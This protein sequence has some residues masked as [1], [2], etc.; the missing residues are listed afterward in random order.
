M[1]ARIKSIE[2]LVAS[3]A[4]RRLTPTLGPVQLTLLGIGAV[5]GSGI[6]VLTAEAAQRA[7]PGMMISFLIAGF[8]CA[9][10]ALCYAE[11]TAMIPVAGS[12]YTYTYAVFGELFAWLIGWAL[13]AEYTVAAG[14]VSVGWSGYFVSLL[15]NSFGVTLPHALTTGYFAGGLL[16]VPGIAVAAFVVTLLVVGTRTSAT[17][18]AVFVVIKVT[19]LSL[20]IV[21]ALPA[22]QAENFVPFAPTGMV[23]IGGAAAS[24]F[25]AYVGFDAVSTAAEETKNPQRNVPIGLVAAMAICAGLFVLTGAAAVGAHGGQP[26]LD[27]LSG[28]PLESG[29]RATAAAC[30]RT[31][32]QLVCSSDPLAFVLRSL[33]HPFAGRAIGLAAF[34]ALPSVMLMMIFGQSRV[35]FA[36][37]RDGLLPQGLSKLHHRF[38]SP[39]RLTL[40]TGAAVVI[41]AGLFPI[42]RLAELSNTGTLCAF[43]A[44][45]IA[46]MVLRRTQPGRERPFR[47]PLIWLM[48]PVAVA[49]CLY[50]IASLEPATRWAFAI[51]AAIGLVVY[52]SYGR[53]HSMMRAADQKTA[54]ERSEAF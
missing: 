38:G 32:E 47:T 36:M 18:N 24:I 15:H 39:Y 34:V 10:T 43:V 3:A 6:F 42:G 35:L 50:L 27:A 48:G 14:A 21:L 30:A 33:G 1:D 31:T 20:F 22:A 41:G 13:I 49:G 51:W 19:A 11:L 45:S 7:G 23:G 54:R 16:N 5:I 2:A 12:A 28:R 46:V 8:V 26:L 44:V 29:S 17:A 25:F 52:Y 37:S 4:R 9:V 53:R 40:L